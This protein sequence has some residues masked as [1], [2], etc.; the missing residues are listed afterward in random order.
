M[1]TCKTCEHWKHSDTTDYN[2]N[3]KS[4]EFEVRVCHLPTQSF[5]KPPKERNGFGVADAEEY[6]AML[7]TAED[8]GCVRWAG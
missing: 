8:F 1:N 5:C 3:Y 2:F 7:L 6:C 4:K